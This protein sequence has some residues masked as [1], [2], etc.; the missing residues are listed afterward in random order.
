MYVERFDVSK[1]YESFRRI[2]HYQAFMLKIDVKTGWYALV[3]FIGAKTN[4]RKFFYVRINHVVFYENS[5]NFEIYFG[6]MFS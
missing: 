6:L 2:H 4:E 1:M 5:L 3:A